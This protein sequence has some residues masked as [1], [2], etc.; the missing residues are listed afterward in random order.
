MG[1]GRGEFGKTKC[2]HGR[3]CFVVA[4][5]LVVENQ[6]NS[7]VLS[8]EYWRTALDGASQKPVERDQSRRHALSC[9][10]THARA[11]DC[12]SCVKKFPMPPA[13][14]WTGHW[15]RC[16]PAVG[17]GLLYLRPKMLINLRHPQP[18]FNIGGRGGGV[19]PGSSAYLASKRRRAAWRISWKSRCG[20]RR[21][22]L[23]ADGH[24]MTTLSRHRINGQHRQWILTCWST[25]QSC[26]LQWT[27]QSFNQ[28]ANIR[29]KF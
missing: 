24:V 9:T 15:R 8:R 22:D 11:H 17:M 28:S 3:W 7:P 26:W 10:C 5:V 19:Q 13:L 21:V 23:T 6:L 16:A 1:A 25:Y 29:S 4:V 20:R 18:R 27:N 14:Q 2:R 12:S